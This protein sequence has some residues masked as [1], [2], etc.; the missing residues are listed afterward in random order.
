MKVNCPE[1]IANNFYDACEVELIDTE[2]YIEG[3]Y[4]KQSLYVFK[5]AG[6]GLRRACVVADDEVML[7]DWID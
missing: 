4:F 6:D 3:K 5:T 2:Y 7:R 1:A